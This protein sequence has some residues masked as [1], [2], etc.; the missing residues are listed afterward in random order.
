M[1]MI[2]SGYWNSWERYEKNGLNTSSTQ[3]IRKLGVVMGNN[4]QT[5]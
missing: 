5:K 1:L 4:E 2:R 3:Y